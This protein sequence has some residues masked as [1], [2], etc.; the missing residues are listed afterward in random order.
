MDT[1]LKVVDKSLKLEL[2]SKS[3]NLSFKLNDKLEDLYKGNRYIV[4]IN[5]HN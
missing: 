4:E 2:L 1:R 5:S 3:S